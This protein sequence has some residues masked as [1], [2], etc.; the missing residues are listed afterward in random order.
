M[1]LLANL[2]N[3]PGIGTILAMSLKSSAN[4]VKDFFVF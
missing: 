4:I 1:N 2:A 3:H